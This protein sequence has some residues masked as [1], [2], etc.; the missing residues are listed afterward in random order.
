MNSYADSSTLADEPWPEIALASALPLDFPGEETMKRFMAVVLS[1]TLVGSVIAA[2]AQNTTTT[3]TTTTKT[4]K[5][6]APKK[7]GP[8]VSEQ[9]G[10]LK[11]AIEAQQQQIRQLGDQVQT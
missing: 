8:T 4:R 1:M 9:L 11:L 5:K 6:T 3:T 2:Q 7:A 10:E